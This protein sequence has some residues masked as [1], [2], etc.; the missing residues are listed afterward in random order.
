MGRG[1][2]A[3]IYP[4]QREML[5]ASIKENRRRVGANL[6]FSGQT[7]G[8]SDWLSAVTLGT[9]PLSSSRSPPTPTSTLGRFPAGS[10]FDGALTAGTAYLASSAANKGLDTQQKERL[11]VNSAS[12]QLTIVTAGAFERSSMCSLAC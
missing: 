4:T 9:V 1:E 5:I 6:I 8:S 10:R 7:P 2:S 11:N 12:V 3:L